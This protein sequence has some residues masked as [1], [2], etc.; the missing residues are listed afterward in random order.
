VGPHHLL[1]FFFFWHRLH[2]QHISRHPRCIKLQHSSEKKHHRPMFVRDGIST[3]I[4]SQH[5]FIFG[6]YTT[7][8]MVPASP[9]AQQRRCRTH[10]NNLSQFYFFH[11]NLPA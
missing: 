11:I 4:C 1:F 8:D 3:L 2:L 6:Y 9:P 10:T 5:I 7:T